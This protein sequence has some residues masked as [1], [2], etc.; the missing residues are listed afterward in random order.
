MTDRP[1]ETDGETHRLPHPRWAALSVAAACATVGLKFLAY[2]LT[3]SV[4]VLSDALE[5]LVN[6]AAALVLLVALWFGRFP[7]DETHPYGHEKVEYFSSGFEGALILFAAGQIV[8]AAVPRLFAPVPVEQLGP[9]AAAVALASA[10]NLG[11]ALLLLR[12]GKRTGSLAL[13]SDGR[14]L[15]TDVVTS[16]GVLIGLGLVAL[17]GEE[18]LDPVI[19]VGVALH[20][21]YT[22]ASLLRR[23]FHGLMD[24]ALEPD[25]MA[26]LREA[27]DS[28]LGDEMT[29][30]ELRTRR[31]GPRRLAD[32]HVLVPGE[33]SVRDGHALA[34]DVEHAVQE[35]VPGAEIMVHV[36][37]VEGDRGPGHLT[38]RTIA[39]E[40][41]TPDPA[42]RGER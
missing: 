5:S 29:F 26:A 27:I 30:H 25:E 8:L 1:P 42:P 40:K 6:L 14:H 36:E 24:R 17:T 10:V 35:A 19:A 20:I 31:V 23:S 16:A 21:L 28:R 3:D 13:E 9:G 33:L 7:P 41:D 12:Q 22:G 37:P 4:G 2:R 11:A 34:T 18:R 32:V 38:A 39:R 15:L